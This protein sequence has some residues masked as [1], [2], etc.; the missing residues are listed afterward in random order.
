MNSNNHSIKS[1]LAGFTVSFIM[2]AIL[3][4][5]WGYIGFATG[6]WVDGC[7]DIVAAHEPSPLWWEITFQY[8]IPTISILISTYCGF[9]VSQRFLNS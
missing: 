2:L 7:P 1:I 3:F 9:R 8:V 6:V 4:P 5:V